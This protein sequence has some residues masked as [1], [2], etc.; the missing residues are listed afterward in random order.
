[1]FGRSY[2]YLRL[3]IYIYRERERPWR[4]HTKVHLHVEKVCGLFMELP[5]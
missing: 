2:I 5:K 3:Y 1:L 4:F